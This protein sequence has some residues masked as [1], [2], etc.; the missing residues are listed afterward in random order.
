M[1]TTIIGQTGKQF[2]QNT[3]IGTS[4]CGVRIV[5]HKVIGNT[6][7]LTIKT[8]AAGRITGAGKGISKA[9]RRLAHATERVTLKLPLSRFGRS[10]H[11][12]FSVKLRVGFVPKKGARSSASVTVRFH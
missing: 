11:R 1:P 12:P 9:S 10:R 7:Y 6:A 2:K 5:G 3:K 4:G 8:F